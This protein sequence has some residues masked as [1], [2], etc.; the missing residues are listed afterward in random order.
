MSDPSAHDLQPIRASLVA[1]LV[2]LVN[3]DLSKVVKVALV[4]C[5]AC[6]GRGTIG[7]RDEGQ[8]VTC[9]DCGG[10][11][12]TE[13][14]VLDI[15]AIQTPRIGRHVEQWEYKQGQLIPKFRAKSAAFAQ[16]SKILGFDKAVLEI[17]Q[18]ATFTETLSDESRAQYIEQ[19][20]ELALAGK[21]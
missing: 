14:F 21:L 13:A 19:V 1:D 3:L 20:R 12:V 15:D 6:K 18:S 2:D 7:D 4:A 17:A 9:P 5:P 8:H 16:L 10:V 11:A